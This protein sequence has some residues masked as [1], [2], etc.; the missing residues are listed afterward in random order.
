[1]ETN[2]FKAV[3]EAQLN[4]LGNLETAAEQS[5]DLLEAKIHS[6]EMTAEERD[7]ALFPYLN[8][9]SKPALN[10]RINAIQNMPITSKGEVENLLVDLNEKMNDG[11]I[12]NYSD[13]E[14]DALYPDAVLRHQAKKFKEKYKAAQ[15]EY[16]YPKNDE[17]LVGNIVAK[18]AIK[19]TLNVDGITGAIESLPLQAQP[20]HGELLRKYRSMWATEYRLNPENPNITATVNAQF[21][22]EL[23]NNGFF[24]DDTDENAGIYSPTANGVFENYAFKVDSDIQ[25]TLTTTEGRYNLHL[26][27]LH[28]S[29]KYV[30]SA[31]NL[32]GKTLI[33]KALNIPPGQ[34]G[35]VLSAEDVIGAYENKQFSSEIILK[36]RLLNMDPADLLERSKDALVASKNPEHKDLIQIY[37]LENDIIPKPEEKIKEAIANS[38]HSDMLYLLNRKGIDKLT[39]N[40]YIR[41]LE[42]EGDFQRLLGVNPV[43]NEIKAKIEEKR[44]ANIQNNQATIT[45]DS[46]SATDER[47]EEELNQQFDAQPGIF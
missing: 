22:Q 44:E 19:R 31:K 23:T 14:I 7:I 26:K 46:F 36:A 45:A 17:L 15:K 2:L 4:K 25:T 6:G 39:Q 12:V 5:L 40:Q 37:D 34:P 47:T 11:S 16:D 20:L 32:P 24:V 33:D 35:S 30:E 42:V 41:L 43:D 18:R 3:K 27:G 21:K 8:K 29:F 38:A 9:F 1:M 28:N 13:D 10:K